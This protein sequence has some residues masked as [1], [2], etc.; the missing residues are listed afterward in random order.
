M[1]QLLSFICGNSMALLSF[2]SIEFSP[3]WDFIDWDSHTTKK[4][5]RLNRLCLAIVVRVIC[6]RWKI[7]PVLFIGSIKS[8]QRFNNGRQWFRWFAIWI[9][10]IDALVAV[11]Q[12]SVYRLWFVLIATGK[13]HELIRLDNRRDWISVFPVSNR[14]VQC[15]DFHA[16]QLHTMVL[17]GRSNWHCWNLHGSKVCSMSQYRPNT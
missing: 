2:S 15:Q 10:A 14:F 5:K 13:C 6:C 8:I 17:I 1:A 4:W 9:S 3:H 12:S 11:N 16:A 7:C